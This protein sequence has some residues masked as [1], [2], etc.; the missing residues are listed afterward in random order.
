MPLRPFPCSIDLD[1]FIEF[2]ILLLYFSFVVR[3]SNKDFSVRIV[4]SFQP[5]FLSILY[6]IF[7]LTLSNAFEKSMDINI[8]VSL[9]VKLFI[10]DCKVMVCVSAE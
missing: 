2:E 10:C 5:L 9:D 8:H 1:L 7:R 3:F 6:R 4:V